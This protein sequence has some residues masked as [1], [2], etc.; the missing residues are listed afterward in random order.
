MTGPN[1]R[2]ILVGL[3]A[4]AT[5]PTRALGFGQSSKV[6]IAE[7]DLGGGTRSRPDA[8]TRLLSEVR[9]TTSV[10]TREVLA[11]GIVRVKP[12]DPALFDHPFVVCLGDGPF[13]LPSSAGL[14][15]L[16]RPVA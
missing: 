2:Q 10:E 11:Q 4:M 5:L 3:G 1:R 16:E 6:D 9:L 12:D 7:L 15:Q 8:W 13:E 14:E